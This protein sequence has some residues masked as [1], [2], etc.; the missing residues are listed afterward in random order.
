MSRTLNN[1]KAFA[2]QDEAESPAITAPQITD[3]A[4]FPHTGLIKTLNQGIIGNYATSGFNATGVTATQATFADGVVFRQGKKI[5]VTGSQQTIG[6]SI[7]N[8]YHLLVNAT[9][10]TTLT[11][12][13]PTGADLVPAYTADDVIIAVL[14]HTG[15]NPMQIQFLTFNKTENSL[16]IAHDNSSS[17]YTEAATIQVSSTGVDI[18]SSHAHLTIQNTVADG[19]IRIKGKKTSGPTI[20]D[21]V[22]F[23]MDDEIA[24]FG[25][26]ISSVGSI[27]AQSKV[28]TKND[29]TN[30]ADNRILTATAVTDTHNAEAGLEYDGNL[31]VL[32][33]SILVTNGSINTNGLITT[34]ANNITAP[35]GSVSA[36]SIGAGING[37]SNSG[38]NSVS[39]ATAANAKGNNPYTPQN[40]TMNASIIPALAIPL[41]LHREHYFVGFDSSPA[42]TANSHSNGLVHTA[43]T[44][45]NDVGIMTLRNEQ[46]R[47]A[48]NA[49]AA[50]YG[51]MEIFGGYAGFIALPEPNTHDG[52]RVTITNTSS[53]GLYVCVTNNTLDPSIHGRKNR[54]NGGYQPSINTTVADVALNSISALTGLHSVG[55]T[56]CVDLSSILLAGQTPA[57][58]LP[59]LSYTSGTSMDACL[60]KPRESV[61]F[62]GY[63]Q[64][65][66]EAGNEHRD[67]VA[68]QQGLFY[69]Q[70]QA[71][72]TG[73][74]GQWFIEGTSGGAGFSNVAK[75]LNEHLHLP[76]HLSGTSFYC[77]GTNTLALPS[78][79]PVGTQYAVMSITGTT[80]V[81]CALGGELSNAGHLL[82][83][84]DSMFALGGSAL[85]STT[86]TATNGKT[87]V[88]VANKQ[89]QIIG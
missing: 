16:S 12:R 84:V 7:T 44:R 15:N 11:L 65:A 89:W 33:G 41:S 31:K 56:R 52:K 72:G 80:T 71:A 3:G 54:M 64:Q 83:G 14:V 28:L 25:G 18:T 67:D 50:T 78:A 62:V 4:D 29:I 63:T 23:D 77:N 46:N 21:A 27:T 1:P 26:A 20:I 82:G 53:F 76:V 70:A 66:A 10:A 51:N 68:Y 74:L 2:R 86:V 38:H 13:S 17:T 8:G 59:S 79:P 88:Y 43:T 75:L 55:N 39:T 19:E 49:I 6:A 32:T 24:R 81:R 34:T 9:G 5:S 61:T 40:I 36:L 73:S 85:S 42:A 48:T 35:A 30:N 58:I 22:T 60:I 37:I 47:A 45:T 69:E 87:F 57:A